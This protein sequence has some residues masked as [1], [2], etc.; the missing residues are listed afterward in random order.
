MNIRYRAFTPDGQHLYWM[1][2]ERVIGPNAK[3]GLV[4]AVTYLDGKSL[5]RF[6]R[7]DG[8]GGAGISKAD[9]EAATPAPKGRRNR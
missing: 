5:V 3:P 6:D 1:T 9:A 4:E 7:I 2:M 8:P